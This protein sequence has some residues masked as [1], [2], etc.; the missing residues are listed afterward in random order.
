MTMRWHNLLFLH[1]PIPADVIKPMIPEGLELDTFDGS[2][3]IGIVALRMTRVRR[4]YFPRFAA[5]SFAEVNVRTYVW[6]PGRSGVWFFSVDAGN[7]LAVQAARLSYGL[8]YYDARITVQSERGRLH[9][10]S[11]RLDKNSPRAEL[12]V[13]YKPT[14][15][16]YRSAPETLDRWLTD[17]YCLYTVDR[18]GR[19]GYTEIHHAPWPLQPAE[20]DLGVNTMTE[21]LEI[22]LP[23][24]PPLAHFARHLE[25]IAWSVVSID[26]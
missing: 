15:A 14:G 6:S 1:W 13:S 8:P 4:R 19:L 17:R 20:A 23:G 25:V 11:T 12:H 5:L 18:G 9:C 3:W 7:R 26:E 21:P 16:V 2:A 24:T 22:K 10:H